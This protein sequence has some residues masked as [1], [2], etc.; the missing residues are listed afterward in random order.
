MIVRIRLESAIVSS[1]FAE[2]FLY[3]LVSEWYYT[4]I[5]LGIPTLNCS[6]STYRSP[7]WILV[8][9]VS[10]ERGAGPPSTFPSIA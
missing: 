5:F 1:D 3:D 8:G 7:D 9:N 4:G 10:S 2:R 6:H